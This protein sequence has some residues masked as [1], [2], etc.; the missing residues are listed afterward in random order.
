MRLGAEGVE[1][2]GV[3]GMEGKNTQRSGESDRN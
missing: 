1:E 2:G 3:G